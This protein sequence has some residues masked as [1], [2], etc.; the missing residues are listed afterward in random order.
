EYL[1][2][3]VSVEVVGETF[4]ASGRVVTRSGW[5]EVY[6]EAAEGGSGDDGAHQALPDMGEADPVTCPRAERKD[7]MTRPPPRFT[8]GTLIRAMEN[9]HKFVSEPEHKKQLRDGDGIG[10]SATRAA[11]IADL[12]R[13]EFLEAK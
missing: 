8:E 1:A 2:T 13:R 5:R 11:I 4:V 3:K 7:A 6:D 10:T 9:I 12:R